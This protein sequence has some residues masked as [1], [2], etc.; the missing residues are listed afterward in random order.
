MELAGVL[1]MK[2]E[3]TSIFS[4]ILTWL[5]IMLIILSMWLW[6]GSLIAWK[7]L[8]IVGS[9]KLAYSSFWEMVT[10]TFLMMVG[11]FSIAALSKM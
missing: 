9:S 5:S 2:E 3:L 7:I 6:I 10:G 8:L 11:F 1:F 4:I